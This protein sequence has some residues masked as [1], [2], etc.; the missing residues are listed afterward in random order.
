MVRWSSLRWIQELT[1]L[2]RV[3]APVRFDRH[4]HGVDLGESFRV[5]ELQHPALAGLVVQV[6]YPHIQRMSV[7]IAAPSPNLKCVCG[8]HSWLPIQ[9]KSIKQERLAACIK[10]SPEGFFGQA[11]LV[12][13][14]YIGDEE[15]SRS[16]K[17]GHFWLG[18]WQLPHFQ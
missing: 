2:W 4:K 6:H 12:D 17:F 1:A 18:V 13:V 5:A 15:V 16:H 3:A 10:N 9:I 8:F 14:V 11:S 7:A